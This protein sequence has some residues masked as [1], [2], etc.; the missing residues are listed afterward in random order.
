[1]TRTRPHPPGTFLAAP[2]SCG[3]ASNGLGSP[4]RS[5][6]FGS[7]PR[8]PVGVVGRVGGFCPPPPSPSAAN[9]PPKPVKTFRDRISHD[10]RAHDV[11]IVRLPFFI[12]LLLRL[13]VFPIC[14][15]LRAAGSRLVLLE[16]GPR[17]SR[18]PCCPGGPCCGGSPVLLEL[19]SLTFLTSPSP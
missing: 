18:S 17:R 10:T 15:G 12:T 16:E 13:G 7:F 11:G 2:A 5:L 8:S 4:P 6:P 19:A 3:S 1:M 9:S 14:G